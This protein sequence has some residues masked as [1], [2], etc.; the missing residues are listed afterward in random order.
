MKHILLLLLIS[1]AA[2]GQEGQDTLFYK[3]GKEQLDKKNYKKAIDYFSQAIELNKKYTE[4]YF[5]RGEC[6]DKQKK[7]KEALKDYS[8]ASNLK[9]KDSY[10]Y[11]SIG[12]VYV[13]MKNIEEGIMNFN[14]AIT[15]DSL[16]ADAWNGRA[17]IFS[18]GKEYIKAEHD[19]LKAIKYAKKESLGLIY[20]N[21]GVMYFEMKKYEKAIEELTHAIEL[22]WTDKYAYLYRAKAYDAIGK[23]KEA[24]E[25][26]KKAKDFKKIKPVL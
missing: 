22:K 21:F 19:Y 8:M 26:R 11:Y 13:R 23:T 4:A 2:W 17:I 6:F 5:S 3:Q 10:F 18:D 14:K 1:C 25:D 15:C 9:P 20:E 12:T 24:K 7:Y 16:N